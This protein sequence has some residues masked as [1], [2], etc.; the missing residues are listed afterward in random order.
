M[1]WIRDTNFAVGAGIGKRVILTSFMR[2]F[3]MHLAFGQFLGTS[4][5]CFGKEWCL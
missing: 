3:N 4:I 2:F 5:F 1:M